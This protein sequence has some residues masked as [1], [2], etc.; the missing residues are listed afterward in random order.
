M[1]GPRGGS[2]GRGGKKHHKGQRRHFT[3]EEDLAH[4]A[5]KEAR[6]KA[7]RRQKGI[8]SDEDEEG[9]GGGEK[10]GEKEETGA[11]KVAQG[12]PGDLPPS[13]S[14]ESSEEEDKEAKPKGVSHLIEVANP[15][16]MKAKSKKVTEL[17]SAEDIQGP[18]LSRREREELQKQQA[19]AH[20]RKM[21]LEGKTEEAR[22]DLARLAIIKKQREDAARKKE[23]ERKALE[24]AKKEAED[25]LKQ[26]KQATTG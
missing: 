22:S 3:N 25:K 26:K 12:A 20:Y 2:G 23:E 15:N 14:E 1:P 5:E 18:Q 7:W 4:S 24:A 6:Q 11:A 8:E 17:E 9:E 10:G 13:D 16:R 21:H 19:A